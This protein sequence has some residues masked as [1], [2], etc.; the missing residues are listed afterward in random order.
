M[1]SGF[2]L[3]CALVCAAVAVCRGS[4][5]GEV[6]R[7]A[8]L[9]DDGPIVIGKADDQPDPIHAKGLRPALNKSDNNDDKLLFT[10]RFEHHDP[11]IDRLLYFQ[12][13]ARRHEQVVVL[14]ETEVRSCTAVE[15]TDG[16]LT[17]LTLTLTQGTNLTMGA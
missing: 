7:A 10:H 4:V 13:H 9:V 8:L 17:K 6:V 15:V 3:G 14:S 1:Y 12:Y 2:A 16:N 11:S 5:D